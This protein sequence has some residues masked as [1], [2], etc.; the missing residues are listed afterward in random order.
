MCFRGDWDEGWE[1]VVVWSRGGQW[2]SN[3]LR[4]DWL[5]GERSDSIVPNPGIWFYQ[6]GAWI[7]VEFLLIEYYKTWICSTSENIV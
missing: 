4:E 6:P 5:L 7:V 1:D 2:P 3:F